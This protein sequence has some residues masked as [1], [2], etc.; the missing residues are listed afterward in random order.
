MQV[1]KIIN[2]RSI[3]IFPVGDL[4]PRGKAIDIDVIEWLKKTFRFQKY[5]SS[6]LD[7]DAGS[8]N[9][10]FAGGRFKSGK[11]QNGKDLYVSVG[12]TIYNDGLLAITESSTADGDKFLSEGLSGVSKE[13]SLVPP[14]TIRKKLYYNEMDVRIDKPLTLLNRKLETIAKRISEL[15][16]DQSTAFEFS[17]VTFFPERLMQTSLSPFAIERKIN[18]DWSENRYFTKAP[19]QTSDHIILLNEFEELLSA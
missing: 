12:L 9:L 3:W 10:T 14:E 2:A 15:T 7:Y 17:G 1:L 5:P 13:F 4:N 19:L 18:T 11:D 8:Q 16:V 6:A